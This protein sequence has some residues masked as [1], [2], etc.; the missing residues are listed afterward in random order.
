MIDTRRLCDD[1]SDND[2]PCLAKSC[3]NCLSIFFGFVPAFFEGFQPRGTEQFC[4]LIP[5]AAVDRRGIATE[6][7]APFVYR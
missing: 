3:A 2:A 4:G 5:A 6:P 1:I 7:F